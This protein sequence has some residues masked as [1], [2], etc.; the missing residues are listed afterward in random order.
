LFGA[1]GEVI[2]M[3]SKNKKASKV[4]LLHVRNLYSLIYERDYEKP[5]PLLKGMTV[6]GRTSFASLM[7]SGETIS[8][9]DIK[10]LRITIP[11]V[12]LE[13]IKYGNGY[14]VNY[15]DYSITINPYKQCSRKC[16]VRISI[17]F[18]MIQDIYNPSKYRCDYEPSE[19]MPLDVV[20]FFKSAHFFYD[21]EILSETKKRIA[22]V[23][24]MDK[25]PLP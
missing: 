16:L 14:L 22:Y 18:E 13:H 24:E 25:I 5:Y 17:P 10:Y 4:R 7:D 9:K 23:V 19:L 20:K 11:K 12:S 6:N 15:G 1:I 3:P 8:S 2:K 21:T